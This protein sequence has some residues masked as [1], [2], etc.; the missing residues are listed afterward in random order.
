MGC[1]ERKCVQ[2]GRKEET[3]RRNCQ[4]CQRLWKLFLL[5]HMKHFLF[6]LSSFVLPLLTHPLPLS[7][8]SFL[9]SSFYLDYTF[10]LKQNCFI[11]KKNQTFPFSIVLL[12]DKIYLRRELSFISFT[13]YLMRHLYLS[14]NFFLI[15]ALVVV[16]A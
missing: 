1:K 7:F 10:A 5:N 12:L 9:P 2:R 11:K 14:P 6:F 13:I 16:K 3:T 8:L 15:T 4:Q